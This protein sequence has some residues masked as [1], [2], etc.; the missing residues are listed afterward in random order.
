[1]PEAQQEGRGRHILVVDDDNATLKVLD[2]A[3][4]KRGYEVLTAT[5]AAEGLAHL[6]HSNIDAVI[7]DI[8]MP[9]MDGFDFL[10]EVRK[11]PDTASVPFIFL[12]ADRTV[13]SKV[14]GLDLGV[15]EYITKPCVIE[16]LYARL[17]AMI[18]RRDVERARTAAPGAPTEGWDLTGSLATM[19]LAEFLQTLNQ[20]RKTG[21]LRVNTSFG[22]GEVYLEKGEVRHSTF[23]GI[24][25]G[26]EAVYL[27]LAIEEGSFDFR[28]GVPAPMQTVSSNLQS[29]LL[30]G[31]RQKDTTQALLQAAAKRLDGKG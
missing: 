4:K 30:E 11:R 17:A 9:E 10:A 21:V 25:D 14:K 2:L 29:L 26:V 23:A 22:L 24:A 16:E 6:T 13:K 19:P 7:A 12:T 5:S 28:A 3:L 1:M 8:F 31:M 15:D 27:L 20:N 18:R